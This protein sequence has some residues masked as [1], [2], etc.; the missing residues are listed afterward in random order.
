MFG[1]I[2]EKALHTC[3][4]KGTRTF[5]RKENYFL[6]YSFLQN[7]NVSNHPINLAYQITVTKKDKLVLI[8]GS[9]FIDFIAFSAYSDKIN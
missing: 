1:S 5:F 2:A 6:I 8:I 7:P 4:F 9:D 3:P